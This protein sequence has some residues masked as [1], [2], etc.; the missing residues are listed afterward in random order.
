MVTIEVLGE[1]SPQYTALDRAVR[2]A[3]LDLD[4]A[5][6]DA[7]L[8]HSADRSVWARYALRSQPGLVIDGQLVCEGRIPKESEIILWLGDV[9]VA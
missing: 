5:E 9:E 6:V 8:R 4:D 1:P 2:A 7:A 3:L